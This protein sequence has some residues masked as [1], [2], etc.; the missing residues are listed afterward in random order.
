MKIRYLTRQN[1]VTAEQVEQY[2]REHNL[3]KIVVKQQL[4]NKVGPVLQY[5]NE[6]T[7]WCDAES[8]TEY[9]E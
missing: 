1:Q 5:W 6:N 2:A 4:E 7:G 8:V 9:R 3:P